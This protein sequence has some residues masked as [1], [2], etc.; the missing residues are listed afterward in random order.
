MAFF[1]GRGGCLPPGCG[2]SLLELFMSITNHNGTI[3]LTS[4]AELAE[5]LDPATLPDHPAT[6]STI[7]DPTHP[8]SSSVTPGF[9]LATLIARLAS[10][11]GGVEMMAREDSRAREEA[12]IELARYEALLAE[13]G[14]AEQALAESRR[15]R[16][17]AE[18]LASEAFSEEAQSRAAHDV[19]A[20]RA[21]ELQCI[22]VLAERARATMTSPGARTSP[23]FSPNG[24]VSLTISVEP[25]GSPTPSVRTVPPEASLLLIKR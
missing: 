21:L 10:L 25:P 4:F 14:A 15:V 8:A 23:A 22:E 1:P 2:R 9:D 17:A 12:S 20:A 16:A 18:R 24:S 7:E 19:A 13:R 5:V 6:S 3:T 11:S